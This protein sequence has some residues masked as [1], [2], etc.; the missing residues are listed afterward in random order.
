MPVRPPEKGAPRRARDPLAGL[1]RLLLVLG[2][3]AVAGLAVLFAAYRFG[4]PADPGDPSTAEA[5]DDQSVGRDFDYTQT[6]DGVPVFRIRA[7]KSRRSRDDTAFLERVILDIFREDGQ[8]YTVTSDSATWSEGSWQ[9]ELEGDVVL[10]GVGDLVLYSRALGLAQEG[11]RL[12]SRGEVRFEWGEDYVGRASEL[13]VDRN[14]DAI[15]LGGGVHLRDAKD[16]AFGL[17]LDSRRVVY[18]RTAGV[19]RAI[20]ESRV[21]RG[22]DVGTLVHAA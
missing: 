22:D 5:S 8:V 7:E 12:E 14:S 20:G 2:I 11:Q 13:T 21:V 16:E 9:A 19:L 17:R 18:E 6:S 15:V 4:R 1:R 3:L 10:R